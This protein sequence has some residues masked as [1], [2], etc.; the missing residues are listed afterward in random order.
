M[1]P[2]IDQVEPT[3]WRQGQRKYFGIQG[4]KNLAL[5]L[6]KEAV[7]SLEVEWE[8]L[9]TKGAG[10]T[11]LHNEARARACVILYDMLINKMDETE[12][13]KFVGMSRSTMYAARKR[14]QKENQCKD[15][16]SI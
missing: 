7:A 16:T 9:T 1:K 15:N 14:W 12:I 3:P 2:S 13:A 4:E 6:A 8:D 11:R 10:C 5:D